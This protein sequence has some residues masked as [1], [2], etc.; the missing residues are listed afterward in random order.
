VNVD[1]G[2]FRALSERVTT[3]SDAVQALTVK[4][5]QATEAEAIIRRARFSAPQPPPRRDRRG[6]KLV[7]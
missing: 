6:L 5:E 3:L 2:E 1:T 4:V 7:P